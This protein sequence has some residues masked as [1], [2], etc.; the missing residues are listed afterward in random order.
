MHDVDRTQLE[1]ESEAEWETESEEFLGDLVGPATQIIGGLLGVSSSR[2]SARWR[3]PSSRPSC[4]RFRAKMNSRS[5]WATSSRRRATR[6]A[7]S[8]APTPGRRSPG[9]SRTSPSRHC[10]PKDRRSVGT[11]GRTGRP[12]RRTAGERRRQ[13]LWSRA[14]GTQQ[15]GG[16]ARGSQGSR[17]AGRSGRCPC[18][19]GPAWGLAA[20]GCAPGHSRRGSAA[21]ARSGGAHR[22]APDTG[23]GRAGRRS[24][25]PAGTSTGHGPGGAGGRAAARASRDGGTARRGPAGCS[26]CRSRS[27]AGRPG[28]SRRAAAR[29]WGAGCRAAPWTRAWSRGTS[30]ARSRSSDVDRPRDRSLGAVWRAVRRI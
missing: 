11:S 9:P 23:H 5:S 30:G 8:F 22:A 7:R 25:S 20:P 6:S 10:R 1:Y 17:P 18:R 4:S 24:A 28:R 26:R 2:R 13:S 19:A 12:D 15:R 16:R 27:G 29:A 21:R 3:R 14:G